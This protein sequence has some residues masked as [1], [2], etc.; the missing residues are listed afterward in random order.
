MAV[1]ARFGLAALIVGA[2]FAAGYFGAFASLDRLTGDSRFQFSDRPASGQ[3]V[4]VDIDSASL[5]QV[6]VWPWPRQLH[7]ELLDRL[8]GLG[9][10][11]VAFDIDFSASSSPE[12]DAALAAALEAAGG[13]AY[14]AAFEQVDGATRALR[15]S[16]PIEAFAAHATA[17]SV[18]VSATRDGLIDRF[19]AATTTGGASIAALPVALYG[20]PAPAGD[21]HIDYGINLR[22]I[23]RITAGDLLAGKVDA[24]RVVDRQV[25]IGASAIELRDIFAVPRYGMLPG[26]LV[27]IA[28]LETLKA[29]RALT[30][31]GD[32]PGIAAA[33]LLALVFAARGGLRVR[34]ATAIVVAA[35]GL[36]EVAALLL[37]RQYGLVLRTAGFEI[38]AL[39]LLGQHVAFALAGEYGERRRAQARLLYLAR[40]DAATDALSRSG[41]IEHMATHPAPAVVLVG[42]LRMDL[43]RG[44]LGQPVAELALKAIARRLQLL[45]LGAVGLI[46]RDVFAIALQ[47][48]PTEASLKRLDWGL[49]AA[50]RPAIMVEGHN[51]HVDVALAL[52]GA[53]PD[54]SAAQMLER[55]E[56]ALRIGAQDH[57]VST[58]EP[59]METGVDRRRRIDAELREA[60][61]RGELTVVF[62]P[63]ISLSDGALVGVEALVRWQSPVLG[64]V[65]PADFIPLAEETGLIVPLG[66]FVLAEACKA[67]AAWDWDG[68]LAV[69]VSAAQIRLD[70]I[71]ERVADVLV[72]TGFEAK[73][74]DL[75]ITESVLVET[76]ERLTQMFANLRGLGVGIA[77]DDFGTGYSSLSY[78]SGLDFDKLKIDQSFVR[79]LEAGTANAAIVQ[80]IVDL[81][82]RL[83]KTTVAEGVETEAQRQLLAGMGCD[84]GQGYLIG[85]PV[86]AAEI[87]ARIAGER[88][89]A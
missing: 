18:N 28:G 89:V 48:A 78:L 24:Q 46:D 30:P 21:I 70:D 84:I 8:M 11:E 64:P 51:V 67:A 50:L 73:R 71:G 88:A 35:V 10:A 57:G 59:S 66:A 76:P 55:A 17:A 9:A 56:L 23:D 33:A 19:A 16:L 74:L 7:A 12:G 53:S 58:F 26:P 63:Q 34:T 22:S 44:A 4:F 83:G 42:V 75:E 1:L 43:V 15:L 25:V 77:I 82:R 65:S 85:R 27:Q 81:A 13:Y 45:D 47:K 72:E 52:D 60:I 36:G 32:W 40:H 6:G 2:V 20:K 41:L 5:A 79:T 86:P 62:Q 31:L 3:V 37:Q 61:G 69:N 68:R 80:T 54:A 39:L 49:R 87:A 29:G 38:A 14:L